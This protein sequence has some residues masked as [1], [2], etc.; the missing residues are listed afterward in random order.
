MLHDLRYA[1]RGLAATPGF[2][3]VALLTLGLGIGANTAVF[4]LLDDALYQRLPVRDP[5]AL[6]TLVVT[7][8]RN[9]EM[10]NVPSELFQALRE[11]PRAFSDVFAWMRTEMNVDA[12]GDAERV[13]VQYVSGRYYA[14]LGV[15]MAVGRP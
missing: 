8:Q 12:G 14:S 9:E 11:S 5:G 1:L 7:S 4:S 6:R 2:T 13:L 10:S 3:A 15:A